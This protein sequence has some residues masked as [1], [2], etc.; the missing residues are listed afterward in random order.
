MITGTVDAVQK[1]K[2]GVELPVIAGLH[3]SKQ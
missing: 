3:C 1:E 2:L